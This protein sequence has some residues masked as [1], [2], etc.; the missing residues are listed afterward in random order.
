[1]NIFGLA[2]QCIERGKPCALITVIRTSGSVPRHEGAKMLVAADGAILGGTV[3]GGEMESRAIQ[4]AQQAI[5]TGQTR[6]VSYQLA[7]LA[8]GDPGVCGGTVELFIEPLLPA[9]TLL[10][11]GAGHVGRALTH[12]AKWC[13]FRVVVSDDRAELCTPEQCPGADTYLPGPLR[14]RLAEMPL[15]PQTYVALVTRGYPIDVDALPVL[16]DSPVAYIGVIGSQR[17]WLTAAKVLRERGVSDAALQRVRAPIGLELNAETPEEIAVSI[18]AE[19]IMQRR[20]GHGRPM[21]EEGDREWE[22]GRVDDRRL[23]MGH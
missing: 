10:I 21:S 4:L 14:A 11:V 3:G 16:L 19:I 8:K 9:P 18:M 7:D 6:T 15:T 22:A 2:S 17:R 5:T 12:L 23:E 20:G 13:G 1:M